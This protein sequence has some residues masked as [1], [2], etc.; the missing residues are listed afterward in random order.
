MC[1]RKTSWHCIYC[2]L[3]FCLCALLADAA[4]APQKILRIAA[5]QAENSFDPAA[6]SEESSLQ[7]CQNM[8]D[9][10]LTYDLLARPVKL[11]PN[12]L[13][14]LPEVSADGTTYTFH[15]Q[16]G[17]YFASDPAFKGKRRELVAA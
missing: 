13:T 17:I 6:E 9:A 12:T 10:M 16:R 3:P 11:V 1:D 2:L 4:E 15:V 5:L 14:A 7:Y 8:F